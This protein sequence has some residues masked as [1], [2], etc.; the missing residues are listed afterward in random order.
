MVGSGRRKSLKEEGVRSMRG[1]GF[2]LSDIFFKL[3]FLCEEID[4]CLLE[5]LGYD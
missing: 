1:W 2:V 3:L 4:V 5:I